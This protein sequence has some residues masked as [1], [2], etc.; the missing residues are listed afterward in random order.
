MGMAPGT[1]SFSQ[2]NPGSARGDQRR[3]TAARR[4]S[5]VGLVIW[6]RLA[7]PVALALAANVLVPSV[8]P[9]AAATAVDSAGPARA[10]HAL[11]ASVAP[12]ALRGSAAN[13]AAPNRGVCA[14]EPSTTGN[15]QVNCRREDGT[16]TQN[17]QSETSVAASDQRVVVA[18][19]DTFICCD[20]V[21]DSVG[22]SVSNNGGRSF[23]DMG[24]MPWRSDVQ[25]Y[26]DPWVAVAEDGTIYA[27]ALAFDLPAT[28]PN[29]QS[30]IGFYRMRP[31]DQVFQFVSVPVNVPGGFYQGFDADK[32]ALAVGRDGTGRL[33]FYITWT[34][35]TPT[36][37]GV[38]IMLTDSVDGIHWRT[39]MV[40]TTDG[41]GQ[42][43]HPVPAG[44]VVYVSWLEFCSG[45]PSNANVV[46]AT[47]RV[48]SSTVEARTVV[49]AENGSGDKVVTCF[50]PLGNVPD[51]VI[52]T[53]PGH[54]ARVGFVAISAGRDANGTLYVVWHDRPHGDGGGFDNA[55]RI[56][57]SYSLDG[58]RTWSTPRVISGSVS[59]TSM[60]DRF[61]P[62]IT[63]REDGILAMWY[64]RV[65]GSPVDLLRTDVERL[66]LADRLRA[67]SSQKGEQ[68]VSS[69]AFPIVQ[70]NPNQDQFREGCYMGD[71][72]S[73][74]TA[75]NVSGVGN[76]QDYAVVTWGDN[77]TVAQT[78][79]GPE[80]Q[81][82]VFSQR[83]IE[84]QN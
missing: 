73:I 71:Y 51:E 59:T 2:V 66:S 80:N 60:R 43:S 42:D 77:R 6:R 19:N 5:V 27:T 1:L 65:P 36:L 68:P 48:S 24:G 46:M 67:P 41:C 12:S 58:N 33:H 15:V 28:N 56:Y 40:S 63:V 17:T 25:P 13:T 32:E 45:S 84:A 83:L 62:A 9:L 7:R 75:P 21:T 70:T 18:Y 44:G 54:D 38:P 26:S 11:R 34:Y 20:P 76:F 22:Y 31:S 39:S 61:Q 37:V 81:P 50:S 14:A 64:E 74:T 47:V 49:A 79:A 53:Q 82:D 16:S 23:V 69:V 4:A 29:T 52:E 8:T 30:K 72:N 57:L 35:F 3:R 78:N 10:A 55:T